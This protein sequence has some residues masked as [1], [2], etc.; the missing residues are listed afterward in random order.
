[1]EKSESQSESKA[2]CQ[3]LDDLFTTKLDKYAQVLSTLVSYA[4]L[5]A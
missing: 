4:I 1:M 2:L 3:L 5:R